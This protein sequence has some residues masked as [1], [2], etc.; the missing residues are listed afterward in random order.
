MT[1]LEF[2]RIVYSLIV[3]DDPSDE[4]AASAGAEYVKSKIAREVDKDLLLA[5]SY[6]ESYQAQRLSLLGFISSY[7]DLQYS[8]AV[9]ELLTV[10]ADR[11]GIEQYL[12]GQI[13]N[14]RQDQ[15]GLAPTVENL[16]RSA[17]L[18]L[19]SHIDN[20]RIQR[21]SCYYLADAVQLGNASRFRIPDGAAM[22]DI[23]YVEDVE[24]LVP[25]VYVEG[26]LVR[27]N[28][29]V[30][31]VI[32][33]GTILEADI[34][35]GLTTGE[36]DVVV[37]SVGCCSCDCNANGILQPTEVM[38]GVTFRY[39]GEYYEFRKEVQSWPWQHR[40]ALEATPI[41]KTAKL[42]PSAAI[43]PQGYSFY[44][45][46]KLDTG[47]H[48]EVMWSGILFDFHDG[49]TI[50]ADEMAAHAVANYVR[51]HLLKMR[52]DRLGAQLAAQAYQSQRS[53]LYANGREKRSVKYSS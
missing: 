35:S 18:D 7:T 24:E 21:R 13:K 37:S 8:A 42:P 39:L 6:W 14:A 1:Y 2:K 5:K 30:Y 28:D 41:S 27:S 36:A 52:D 19:M 26:D 29:R 4:M 53:L 43:D 32:V 17:L 44:A 45:W 23:F 31:K 33:G 48:Y 3:D 10:D 47:H 16:I 12:A 34:G 9:K 50:T 40:T 22:Q 25:G 46:P 38:G 15:E 51:S 20:Y 49:D 11:S